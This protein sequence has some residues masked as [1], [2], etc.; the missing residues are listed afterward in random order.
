MKKILSILLL[1][2]L[3]LN[4]FGIIGYYY[5]NRSVIKSEIKA[6]MKS[7]IPKD[8]IE[9]VVVPKNS[10]AYKRIHSKEFRFHGNMYDIIKE[11]IK[12]DSL[13][14]ICIN[15]MKEQELMQD[16]SRIYFGSENGIVSTGY[17][18]KILNT[19]FLPM[20]VT[21]LNNNDIKNYL[22]IKY[23]NY[24]ENCINA[25]IEVDLPPPKC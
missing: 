7:N 21:N 2:L 5:Y 13:H 3:I 18:G 23:N 22:I 1:F 8:K 11:D 4:T 17:T 9:I 10:K 6:I 14:F 15:D 16:F 20:F 25:Y 24:S 12:A 19:V